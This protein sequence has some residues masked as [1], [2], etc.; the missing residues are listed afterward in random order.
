MY[1]YFCGK[2]ANEDA[3]HSH[4]ECLMAFQIELGYISVESYNSESQFEL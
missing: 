3:I 1:R 2:N 4:V